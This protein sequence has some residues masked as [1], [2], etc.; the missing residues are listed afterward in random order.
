[1]TDTPSADN[2]SGQA[3]G[4][5]VEQPVRLD[6]ERAAF[7]DWAKEN[8]MYVANRSD[9]LEIWLAA[10]AA[11]SERRAWRPTETA[12]RDGTEVLVCRVY[13]DG[14]AEYAVAHNYDDGNGWRDMGDLGWAGM[15]HE[16]DNQPTH[17]MPLPPPP[18]A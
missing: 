9:A 16:E 4:A 5:P 13:E 17:W 15:S 10:T 2:P 6:P 3:V 1:M 7:E 14:K 11:E 12:P 8:W 18:K